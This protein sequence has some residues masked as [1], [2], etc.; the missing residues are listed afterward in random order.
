MRKNCTRYRIFER[1]IKKKI[2]QQFKNFQISF[3]K[4]VLWKQWVN[5]TYLNSE[6]KNIT[7]PP[8]TDE[9]FKNHWTKSKKPKSTIEKKFNKLIHGQNLI[10]FNATTF[11]LSPQH[12]T[13]QVTRSVANQTLLPWMTQQ[14][15]LLYTIDVSQHDFSS[16]RLNPSSIRCPAHL[17]HSQYLRQM[18]SNPFQ[19]I[20]KVQNFSFSTHQ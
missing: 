7:P 13:H 6:K 3:P 2:Q 11:S 19:F 5:T 12:L 20:C 16:T 4:L 17:R 10:E 8:I 9:T 14:Y 18:I 1:I 15:V